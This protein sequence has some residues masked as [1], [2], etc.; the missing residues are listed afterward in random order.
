MEVAHALAKRATCK[1]GKVGV[2]IVRAHRIVA[3]GYNGAPSL[4]LHCTEAD[5]DIGPDGGCQRAVHAEANAI[6]FSARDGIQLYGTT[7]YTTHSPCR[8]CAQLIIN[9]G[10]KEVIY[11]RA[12]RDPSGLSLLDEAGVQFREY[13]GES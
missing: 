7:L 13:N 2:V 11:N 6:A 12:Y 8:K 1:R 9:A 3:T 4:M 5:C 10:I